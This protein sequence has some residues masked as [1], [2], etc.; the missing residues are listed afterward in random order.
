MIAV[1][2]DCKSVTGVEITGSVVGKAIVGIACVVGA[3]YSP[4]VFL[5]AIIFVCAP[6]LSLSTTTNITKFNENIG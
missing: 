2:I 3:T 5:D 1:F 4:V 6:P